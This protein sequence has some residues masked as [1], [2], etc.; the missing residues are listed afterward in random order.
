MGAF[1]AALRAPLQDHV[2]RDVEK[3]IPPAI[4]SL[5]D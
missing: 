1:L 4:E 3:K 5:Q 2:D